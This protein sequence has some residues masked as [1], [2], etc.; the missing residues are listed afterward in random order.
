MS[1]D[2]SNSISESLE[3]YTSTINKTKYIKKYFVSIAN[4]W[5]RLNEIDT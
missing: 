1:G 5:D 2:V 4:E 3:W